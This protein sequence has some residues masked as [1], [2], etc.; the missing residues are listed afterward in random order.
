MKRRRRRKRR[1][2]E[3][4]EVEAE[5]G[6]AGGRSDAANKRFALP[7]VRAATGSWTERRRAEGFGG[8]GG[9]GGGLCEGGKR[10]TAA[11]CEANEESAG[12]KG[13]SIK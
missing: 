12:S 13:P 3:A 7:H 2:R 5:A 11:M 1:R 8:G 6:W 9:G 4:E 10:A